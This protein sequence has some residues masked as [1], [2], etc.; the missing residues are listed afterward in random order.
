MPPRA[1]SWRWRWS[2]DIEDGMVLSAAGVRVE[3][4]V[5]SVVVIEI[6]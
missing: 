1:A 5:P 6:Q 3:E 4:P 2:W